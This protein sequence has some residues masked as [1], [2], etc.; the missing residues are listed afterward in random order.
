[1][2]QSRRGG[3]KVFVRGKKVDFSAAA[4]NTFFDLDNDIIPDHDSLLKTVPKEELTAVICGALGSDWV[5]TKEN[6]LKSTCLSRE[7]KVWL[8]FVNASLLPTRHL[9]H[10]QLDRLAL[11]YC[12][13]KGIKINVGRIISSLIW[14]KVN[15]KK[16]KHI[17][18]PTAITELCRTTGVEHGEADLVTKVDRHIT[19]TVVNVHIKVAAEPPQKQGKLMAVGAAKSAKASAATP[20]H[21]DIPVVDHGAD[22]DTMSE[23]IEYMK[24]YHRCQFIYFNSR[25]DYI[26]ENQTKLMRKA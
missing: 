9:N 5:S 1:M 17:W 12:I 11:I 7:A 18:F 23:Q 14:K 2:H 8:H 25:L 15:D 20:K 10:V 4:I 19:K 6:A 26:C 13:L 21:I 3:G 22:P 24:A 16:M